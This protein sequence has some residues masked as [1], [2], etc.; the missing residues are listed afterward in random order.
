MSRISHLLTF[1]LT[2][3]LLVSACS[4]SDPEQTTSDDPTP[5]VEPTDPPTPAEPTDPPTPADPAPL[6][7]TTEGGKLRGTTDG[8]VRSFMGIPY[9]A[10]P[11][12]GLRWRSPAPAAAWESVREAKLAGPPCPQNIPVMNA[13]TG[14]EDCLYLNVL[15]PDPLPAGPAPVMVW[16]HGGGFTSGDGRH[17]T[18]ATNGRT[19]AAETGTIVVT[20]NYRLGQL[21]FLAHHALT[22]E[23]PSRPSSGNYGLE[24]QVAALEWIERNIAAFGGDPENVTIFGESA[25]GISVCALLASPLS[26]GLFHRGIIQSGPCTT[27]FATLADAERQGE[28]FAEQLGCGDALEVL[29]CMRKAPAD[30]VAAALPPDP[31]FFFSEGEFGSWFPIVDD[32]VLTENI[33]DSFASGSF[34]RVPLLVGSNEDEGT[35][36][37]ALS[38]DHLGR[39]LEASQYRDRI[40]LLISD[41]DETIDRVEA[42]YPLDA[43]ETPGLALSESFGD[44]ALACPTIET[45]RLAADHTPT[46]LYQFDYP[47]A[48][49]QIPLNIEIDLGAFHSAEISYAFGTPATDAPFSD[50]EEQLATSMVGYWTRF[51]ATG[52]PNGP[53]AVAWPRLD[54]SRRHLIL[55]TEVREATGAR[56]DACAFW[57]E[58]GLRAR[59]TPAD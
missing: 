56:A 15:T 10:P 47:D 54:D 5:R 53:G 25:G 27:K 30:R 14:F 57:R 9:A 50:V 21:G 2:V 45:A 18:G 29:E 33:A 13:P 31:A 23:D 8:G 3:G 24:D 32:F 48:A 20:L 11:V 59:L 28:R 52:D 17:Y 40:A 55:S 26:G 16:I 6:D 22:N 58:L 42:R 36:F 37:V 35:L 7:V 39:P 41:D 44:A 49:F 51:A 4:S 46:Y 19:I 34:H 1:A 12:E 38:H 43:F